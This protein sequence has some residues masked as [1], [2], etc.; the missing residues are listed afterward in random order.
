[1]TSSFGADQTQ[2][3]AG[4]LK[5]LL[6]PP[7]TST[8]AATPDDAEMSAFVRSLVPADSPGTAASILDHLEEG[9][10]E[11]GFGQNELP[12]P[13]V[14]ALSSLSKQAGRGSSTAT[15]HA[16][17]PAFSEEV[18]DRVDTGRL[19]A[20]LRRCVDK[21]D[22]ET[23]CGIWTDHKA[24]LTSPS[25]GKAETEW[26]N[27]MLAKILSACLRCER[28]FRPAG[29]KSTINEIVAC[30]PKPL[31][32]S[33]LNVILAHRAQI[34]EDGLQE[35]EG[36]V[37]GQSGEVPPY[38]NGGEPSKPALRALRLAW[39]MAGEQGAR[40]DIRSY[41][42]YMEGLARSGDIACLQ[43]T[44]SAL[45]ANT[46]LKKEIMAEKD[47]TYPPVPA[48]N[49]MLSS[50][51]LIPKTG[52]PVALELFGRAI[53]SGTPSVNIVTI[54]TVLRHHARMADIPSMTSLF[55]LA[56]QK[57]L[58]PD[59]V[60]YTTLVQGLLRADRVEMAKKVLSKMLSEGLEPNERMCSLL[61]SDLARSGS[62]AG[63]QRA[64]E[65]M[66]EMRRKG[67]SVT[68]VTWTS[69]I[70]GYFRGGWEADAWSTIERMGRSKARL[71]RVGYNMILKQGQGAWCVKVFQKMVSEG[72]LPNS[73]TFVIVLAPLVH[74]KQW[75]EADKVV[76]E[77]KRMGYSPDKGA[78]RRLVNR[79][80]TR[81]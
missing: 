46:D 80:E 44:W 43:E 23:L 38:P 41:M 59:V 53:H 33:L 29:L 79:V 9:I 63:L 71:N 11:S 68:Q 26:K 57:G 37:E 21:G 75:S 77:M 22:A 78:L 31:S 30:A 65:M 1:M 45:L 40:K 36:E 81:R 27:E 64:E 58:K 5:A 13:L 10:R 28:K 25:D 8:L 6:N 18:G 67:M 70:S 4:R 61:V 16:T 35:D 3:L 12:A 52:P 15:D 72:V 42:I 54:N 7:S 49:H 62:Q 17:S 76:Q 69:L 73:D 47:A 60:T 14:S 48:F 32:T 55:S 39:N 51:L 19:Y 24:R 56:G 50:A 74:K 34:D 20:K 66:S 2:D